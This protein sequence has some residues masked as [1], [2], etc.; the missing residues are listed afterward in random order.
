M[1]SKIHESKTSRESYAQKINLNLSM[2]KTKRKPKLCPNCEVT[3]DCI[4]LF[5]NKVNRIEEAVNNYY[6]NFP[7]KKT[8]KF[9]VFNAK[10]TLNNIPCELE[11]DLSK[12]TLENIQKL[13]SFITQN[14]NNNV[15]ANSNSNS[16]EKSNN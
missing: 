8:E 16:S 4:N 9:S 12:F 13:A 6:K 11:Y 3:T 10:F 2:K 14:C 5:S 15:I 1:S 7:K